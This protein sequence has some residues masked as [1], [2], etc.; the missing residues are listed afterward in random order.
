MKGIEGRFEVVAGEVRQQPMKR[1]VIVVVEQRLY[2]HY[3]FQVA[4]KMFA[5]RRAAFERQGGIKRVR[6]GV[7]PVAQRVAA[8]LREC[9]LQQFAVFQRDD[10]PAHVFEQMIDPPEQP[11]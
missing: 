6:A 4:V 8:C 10:P 5:P 3:A 1:P 11:V 2:A 7:Y 9:T